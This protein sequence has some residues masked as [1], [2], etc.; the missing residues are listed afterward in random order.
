MDSIVNKAAGAL[1][2]TVFVLLSVSIASEGIFHSEIPEKPG[3]AIAAAEAGAEGGAAEAA[4]AETPI[5][6]LLAMCC[7]P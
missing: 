1:L 2:G 3:Y 4:V 6:N 7:L 5:A